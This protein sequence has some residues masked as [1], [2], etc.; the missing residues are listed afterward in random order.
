[1]SKDCS[2]EQFFF[3]VFRHHKDAGCSLECVMCLVRLE[4]KNVTVWMGR[5]QARE[6][7]KLAEPSIG[8]KPCWTLW[9]DDSIKRQEIKKS[10]DNYWAPV[11]YAAAKSLQSCPTL[12][13][14]IDGSAPGSPVPGVLQARTLEWVAISFSTS[15]LYVHKISLLLKLRGWFGPKT[16]KFRKLTLVTLLLCWSFR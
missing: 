14:P 11:L 6:S 15:A 7:R 10:K 16:V 4:L 12:C 9:N 5:P 3:N 13:D 8:K 2:R 1:M